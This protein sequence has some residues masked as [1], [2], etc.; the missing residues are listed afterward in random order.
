MAGKRTS[1]IY[2]D[3]N[4]DTNSYF[5]GFKEYSVFLRNS[6]SLLFLLVLP[7][8]LERPYIRIYIRLLYLAQ[9]INHSFLFNSNPKIE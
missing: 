6:L 1:A 4:H 2:K 5:K 7:A 3:T 8:Y 9:L